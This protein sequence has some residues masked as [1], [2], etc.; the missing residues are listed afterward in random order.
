MELKT[1]SKCKLRYLAGAGKRMVI[2]PETGDIGIGIELPHDRIIGLDEVKDNLKKSNEAINMINRK[3]DL[4]KQRMKIERK[5]ENKRLR[6][7][8]RVRINSIR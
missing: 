2:N 8:L 1:A 4:I 3:Q 6:S 5:P 7:L